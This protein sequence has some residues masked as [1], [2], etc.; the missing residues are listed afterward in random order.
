MT[1]PADPSV[2]SPARDPHFESVAYVVLLS[3]IL[4]IVAYAT[5][6]YLPAFPAIGKAFGASPP[7]IQLTLTVFLY[8]NAAGQLFF[9]PLSDRYGRKPILLFG[10]VAYTVATF[11]CAFATNIASFLVY[12]TF[13]GAAAA[14]GPVLIRALLNDRL[15][16]IH[17]AQMLAL[18]IAI[19]ALLGM[20]T[21]I[22]GGFLVQYRTWHW[23]FYAIGSVSI[24]LIVAA[25]FRTYETLPRERRLASLDLTG[26]V[27]GYV[28]IGRSPAFWCYVVPPTLMF[29]GVFAYV[30]ANS[31]LL[32]DQLGMQERY[33]GI[34]YSLAAGAYV[35]GSLASRRLVHI[36]GIDRAIAIGLAAG[37]CSAMGA[38]VAST[39]LP[40]SIPLVVLPALATFFFT[41][42]IVPI[43]LSTAVSLFSQ[44][45]GSASA[46]AGFFQITV[47]GV[48]TA[49][50]AYL[51]TDSI[52]P[53]HTFT[54]GCSIT[55]G[56]D[57]FASGS[58]RELAK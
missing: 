37:T 19:M 45:A 58:M 54:L 53:L 17:A 38:V 57:W 27:R 55:A 23:I 10:L 34:T 43:G 56:G 50:A 28:E 25:Y 36:A 39:L 22:A 26:V 41:A 15:D 12:R 21:P 5:D 14:S 18:L 9:G 3:L 46:V 49:I 7:T 24:V 51:V 13:Q 52:L 47:A 6:M 42:L 35:A 44:R 1:P 29:A 31:F 11:A 33:H 16:R 20:L 30:G 40:L 4:G 32:I 8:G 48:A 2:A